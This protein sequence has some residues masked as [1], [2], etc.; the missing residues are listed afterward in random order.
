MEMPNLDALTTFFGVLSFVIGAMVGSFLNVCVHRLPQGLSVV[1]PRSRCPKCENP[2]AWHDNIPILSWLILGAKC[3][4]C[5]TPI[6]WQYP[7]VESLTAALFFLVYWKFGMTLASPVYMLL[8]ASLVLVTFVDLTDW[9][10]PNEVTFPGVPLGIGCAVMAMVYPESGLLLARP[11]W[12]IV[13]VLIGGGLLYGLDLLSLAILKKRGMGFGD[14]KLMAMLG[15]FFGPWGVLLI[16]VI[17]SFFG[18]AVGLTLI[19]IGRA[20]DG[21]EDAG[22]ALSEEGDEEDDVMTPGGHYLPFGPYIV[23]GGI[24]YLFFGPEIIERYMSYI[25]VPGA[26]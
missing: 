6:S 22:A 9:T 26:I 10:I 14:V 15:A 25:T 2:I 23:L 17:A 4:N 1:R 21:A 7:L 16:L 20:K 5:G 12:S 18:S 3:R 13:G 19:L 8:A 11:L 24:I